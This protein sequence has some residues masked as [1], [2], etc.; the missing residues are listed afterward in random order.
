VAIVLDLQ[1]LIPA[2]LDRYGDLSG[3]GVDAVLEHL[4]ERTGWSLHHLACGDPVDHIIV[5]LP[6]HRQG[7]HVA[8]RG[9]LP[10]H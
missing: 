3:A 4:L 8:A 9:Q 2:I 6:Y 10:D 7:G 1:Q 5:E